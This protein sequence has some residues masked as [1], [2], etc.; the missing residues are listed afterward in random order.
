MQGGQ[1]PTEEQR[2]PRATEFT[3]SPDFRSVSLAGQQFLLTGSQA[4]VIKVLYRGWE[5]G[6]PDLS[7]EEVMK[8]AELL[9]TSRL[10]D[11]FRSSRKER[12]ALIVRRR[13][14]TLRLDLP[15]PPKSKA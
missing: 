13:K 4:K 7:H 2:P 6:N 15:D 10:R 5:S 12:E 1:S 3:H 11:I 9:N 14:G 8:Q